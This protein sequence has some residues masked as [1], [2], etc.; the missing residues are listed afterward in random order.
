MRS[1]NLQPNSEHAYS[2]RPRFYSSRRAFKLWTSFR[3]SYIRWIRSASFTVGLYLKHLETF[4]SE[5]TCMK[6]RFCV[7][8]V[9]WKFVWELAAWILLQTISNTQWYS[10]QTSLSNYRYSTWFWT[11]YL[12]DSAGVNIM[13]MVCERNAYDTNFLSL[14]ST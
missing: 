12:T 6:E 14:S 5:V 7:H 1:A 2:L 8:R 3:N 13:S 9:C 10:G 4:L 11:R